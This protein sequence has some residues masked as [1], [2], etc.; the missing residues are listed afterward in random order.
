MKYYSVEEAR[1]MPGL[2]LVLT[3]HMP[4]PWGEAA[5]A[6]LG[7]RNVAYIPVEQLA[8][9][10]NED[11]FQWTGI[12]NAPIAVLDDE[13][14]VHTWLDILLL[15]ERIGTGPSLMPEDELDRALMMGI[16][17]E[18]CGS[19]GF[20]WSRRLELM[21]RPSTKNPTDGATYDMARMIRMYGVSQEAID[22]APGRMAQIMRGLAKQLHKQEAAGSEYLVT[23]RLTYCDLHWASLS[24]FVSPLPPEQCA[25]PDFMRDNYSHLTPELAD[26]LDPILLRHRDRVYERHIAL[27]LDF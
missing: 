23:D 17:T 7:A 12:R 24:L 2:R 14:P 13:P 27:P 6:V 18:L 22:R 10:P 16:S 15:A 1:Q 4:G 9:E 25:M 20:G 8:M 19:D 26:A 21:G 5:K 3:A 11:L